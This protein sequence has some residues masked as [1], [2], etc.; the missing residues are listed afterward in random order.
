[1]DSALT[2]ARAL[3]DMAQQWLHTAPPEVL[4]AL[5]A[6]ATVVFGWLAWVVYRRLRPA[7]YG[8]K[9]RENIEHMRKTAPYRKR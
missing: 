3:L 8:G 4:L 2:E 7:R 6:S 5:L 9:L 1:M